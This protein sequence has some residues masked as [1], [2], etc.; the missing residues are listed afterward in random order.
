MDYRLIY[1]A[2]HIP[3]KRM[4]TVYGY[5]CD[6]VFEDSLDGDFTSPTLPAKFEDCVMMQ[7]IGRQDKNGKLIFE[8]DILKKE[9]EKLYCKKA[10]YW[11]NSVVIWDRDRWQLGRLKELSRCKVIENR[12]PDRLEGLRKRLAL[13]SYTPIKDF[14]NSEVVGNMFETPELLEAECNR[15]DIELRRFS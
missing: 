15:E 12:R 5:N 14:I 13:V 2:W 3:T 11:Y 7:C 8:Y 4:F 1:R 10:P 6:F 9:S